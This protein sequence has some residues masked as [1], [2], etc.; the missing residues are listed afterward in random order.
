M[1]DDGQC[2][3]TGGACDNVLHSIAHL[4]T[5]ERGSPKKDD[6]KK[7][8]KKR[9][10]RVCVYVCCV[11]APVYMMCTRVYMCVRAPVSTT[12][13][14]QVRGEQKWRDR[15]GTRQSTNS[16][17]FLHSLSK[18]RGTWA[19]DAKDKAQKGMQT[20]TEAGEGKHKEGG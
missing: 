7:G 20:S 18:V 4:R 15:A 3:S 16:D 2:Y 6:E 19:Q 8:K 10:L 13:P 11:C 9:A 12:S 14:E 1:A 5:G 17:P